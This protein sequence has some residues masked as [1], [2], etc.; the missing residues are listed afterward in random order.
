M[1]KRW[2]SMTIWPRIFCDGKRYGDYTFHLFE[3]GDNGTIHMVK[4]NK[5]TWT[6]V[7]AGYLDWPTM[8]V[9]NPLLERLSGPTE[10]SK[11]QQG[12]VAKPEIEC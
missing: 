11:R 8:V 12:A 9:G 5:G 6:I 7:D 10:I 1:T 3:R 2:F 4:Y